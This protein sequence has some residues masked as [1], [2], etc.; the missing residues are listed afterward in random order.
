MGQV[1]TW[2]SQG[3]VEDKRVGG[4]AAEG[5][6]WALRLLLGYNNTCS[7]VSSSCCLVEHCSNFW[8]SESCTLPTPQPVEMSL[9]GTLAWPVALMS[10]KRPEITLWHLIKIELNKDKNKDECRLSA[11]RSG[12]APQ[13]RP[14][15]SGRTFGSWSLCH[16]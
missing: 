11:S 4:G 8:S 7:E 3:L 14:S 10:G 5:G 6:S 9:R 2:D 1:G 16:G 15:S 12:T 13:R